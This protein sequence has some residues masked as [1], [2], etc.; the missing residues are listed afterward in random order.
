[1]TQ[2][3]PKDAA[4]TTFG[5]TAAAPVVRLG[6]AAPTDGAR[7]CRLEASG[8]AVRDEARTIGPRHENIASQLK[9]SK[10]RIGTQPQ[11]HWAAIQNASAKVPFM[12]KSSRN[13]CC[14][15]G[16]DDAISKM[17]PEQAHKALARVT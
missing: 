15:L 2:A 10:G 7:S 17:L 9:A 12:I 11:Y 3:A 13:N 8:R 5:P 14:E 4:L 1:L 6:A 16:H